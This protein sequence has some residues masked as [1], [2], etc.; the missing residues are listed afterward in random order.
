M[1]FMNKAIVC[2][3]E[4]EYWIKCVFQTI[5]WVKNYD[6][7]DL[8]VDAQNI[9]STFVSA[10]VLVFYFKGRIVTKVVKQL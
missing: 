5:R 9:K 1:F 2:S 8:Y 10:W 7:E 4:S 6:H 3:R